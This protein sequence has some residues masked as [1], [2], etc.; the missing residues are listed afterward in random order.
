MADKV[1]SGKAG[2]GMKDSF[3][4][5]RDHSTKFKRQKERLVHLM[6]H[7]ESMELEYNRLGGW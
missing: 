2:R 7:R 1:E 6:N 3:P 4:G 5:R